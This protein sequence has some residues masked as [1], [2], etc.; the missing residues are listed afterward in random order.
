MVQRTKLEL[1]VNKPVEIELLYDEPIS[2]ESQYGNYNLYAVRIDE[3]EYAFFPPKE[4]HESLKHLKA[5]DKAVVTKLAA[6][7]GSKIVSAYDVSINGKSK[8]VSDNS[9]KPEV[10]TLDEP[11]RE[12]THSDRYYEIMLQSFKDAIKISND[13]NGMV[14]PT[15]VAITLFIQ[16]TKNGNGHNGFN[17]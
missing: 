4:V 9:T 3:A 12:E 13:L 7:R 11:V 8:S 15:R 2:G 6:Q 16:R 17:Y 1:E 5:G 10:T 14:E